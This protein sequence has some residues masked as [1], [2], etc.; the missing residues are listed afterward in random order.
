MN[1]KNN[2]ILMY[3]NNE[4]INKNQEANEELELSEE[5]KQK[6]QKSY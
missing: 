6:S 2:P 5:Q 4:D 3:N 1:C